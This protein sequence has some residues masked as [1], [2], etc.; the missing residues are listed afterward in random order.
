MP[1]GARSRAIG[2]A[3]TKVLYLQV[4][5]LKAYLSVEC[6]HTGSV[7]DAASVPICVRLVLPHLPHGEADHVKGSCD[8]YLQ[9]QNTQRKV[10]Q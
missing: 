10:Y 9:E 8:I 1:M 2:R 5:D 6:C 3:A 4:C 7:Y